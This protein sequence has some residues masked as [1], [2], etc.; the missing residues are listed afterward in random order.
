M[1]KSDEKRD[2]IQQINDKLRD[3]TPLKPESIIDK[4][5]EQIF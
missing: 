1:N 5:D 4:T 3:L 2:K